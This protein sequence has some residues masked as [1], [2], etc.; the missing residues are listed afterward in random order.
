MCPATCQACH[1]N[2]PERPLR[3]T[4]LSNNHI[5]LD[6]KAR[7]A[8]HHQSHVYDLLQHSIAGP[9]SPANHAPRAVPLPGCT[10]RLVST[11]VPRSVPR[12]PHLTTSKFSAGT[13][14]DPDVVLMNLPSHAEWFP[15]SWAYPVGRSNLQWGPSP[16]TSSGPS[17]GIRNRSPE[18][19]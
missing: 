17:L 15:A 8:Q 16:V 7:F 9:Y 6:I 11:T 13:A 18:H 4:N 14:R 2:S 5:R 3:Q 1:P 12:A 10:V 19:V